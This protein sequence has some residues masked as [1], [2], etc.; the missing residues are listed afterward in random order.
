MGSGRFL[1]HERHV[2]ISGSLDVRLLRDSEV[3]DK[4][5][6]TNGQP[7]IREAVCPRIRPRVVLGPSIGTK[8]NRQARYLEGELSIWTGWDLIR[9]LFSN[10]LLLQSVCSWVQ[11]LWWWEWRRRY[12]WPKLL[13]PFASTKVTNCFRLLISRSGSTAVVW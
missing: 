7:G 6:P 11:D 9:L 4:T 10:T 12:D 8:E 3:L 2:R 5:S 13:F 1:H